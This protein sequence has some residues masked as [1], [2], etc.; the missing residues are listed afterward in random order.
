MNILL[1]INQVTNKMKIKPFLTFT[2]YSVLLAF[3]HHEKTSEKNHVREEGFILES[4]FQKLFLL[5][6]HEVQLNSMVE[7]K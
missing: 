4:L 2:C 3:P 1:P 6:W 7:R 5:L